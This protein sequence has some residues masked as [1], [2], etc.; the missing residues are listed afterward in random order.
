[1]LAFL[2]EVSGSRPLQYRVEERR[3]SVREL[4][5][6]GLLAASYL[7]YYYWDVRLQIAALDSVRVIL[8]AA[9]PLERKA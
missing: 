6:L 4:T 5:L 7:H 8:P 3:R 1:M 2:Q 9:V